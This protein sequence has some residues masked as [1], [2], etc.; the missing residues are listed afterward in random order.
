MYLSS[1]Y[2]LKFEKYM[3]NAKVYGP[4]A[5]PAVLWCNA[6]PIQSD[7]SSIRHS[8]TLSTLISS[9]QAGESP[10]ESRRRKFERMINI[11]KIRLFAKL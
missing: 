8:T 3:F 6:A 2:K 1:F 9:L 10:A 5:I 7:G 4:F 11:I